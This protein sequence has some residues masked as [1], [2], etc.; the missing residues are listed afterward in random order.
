MNSKLEQQLA[1][2]KQ[3]VSDTEDKTLQHERAICYLLHREAGMSAK[4]EDLESWA[5]RNNLHIY[6]VKEAQEKDITTYMAYKKIWT[7]V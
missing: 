4:C 5:R 3:R 7:Y 1:D 6:G 2:V